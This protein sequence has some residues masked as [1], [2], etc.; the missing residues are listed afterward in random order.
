MH[1]NIGVM[2]SINRCSSATKGKT[3]R[4]SGLKPCCLFA[5]RVL[6]LSA[7]H[8]NSYTTFIF[9]STLTAWMTA[10]SQLGFRPFPTFRE[11]MNWASRRC[12]CRE[13]FSASMSWPKKRYYNNISSC[14][15]FAQVVHHSVEGNHHQCSHLPH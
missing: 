9:Y 11:T 7:F 5:S 12:C 3:I 8:L 10:K 14:L 13:L 4:L 15:L 6:H 2:R 1:G